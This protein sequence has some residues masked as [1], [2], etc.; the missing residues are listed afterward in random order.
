MISI[1][2]RFKLGPFLDP[3]TPHAVGSLERTIRSNLCDSFVNDVRVEMRVAVLPEASNG[4]S[5]NTQ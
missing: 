2:L 3:I 4:V 1:L 5:H